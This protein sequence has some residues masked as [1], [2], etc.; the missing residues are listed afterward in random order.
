MFLML[1][2]QGQPITQ[3]WKKGLFFPPNRYEEAEVR[4][5][6]EERDRQ[7]LQKKQ[8]PKDDG[9]TSSKNSSESAVDSK[10]KSQRVTED[11]YKLSNSVLI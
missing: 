6:L 5:K 1:I 3:Y 4:K 8:E 10:G 2:K 7:E 9:K 11:V